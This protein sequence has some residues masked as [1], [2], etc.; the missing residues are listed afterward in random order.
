M[1]NNISFDSYRKNKRTEIQAWWGY[2][3]KYHLSECIQDQ[4]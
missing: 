3:W 2:D 4:K 1:E